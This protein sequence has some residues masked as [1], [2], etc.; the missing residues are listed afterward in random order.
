MSFNSAVALLIPRRLASNRWRWR[1]S[2]CS[3]SWIPECF[4]LPCESRGTRHV[5][6]TCACRPVRR[7][8][9]TACVTLAGYQQ[10]FRACGSGD[11]LRSEGDN[12]PRDNNRFDSRYKTYVGGRRRRWTRGME[13]R[14]ELKI[15][16]AA[17][18]TSDWTHWWYGQSIHALAASLT[19]AV[20]CSHRTA[21]LALIR[22]YR[23]TGPQLWSMGTLMST[24]PPHSFWSIC[25]FV[26]MVLWY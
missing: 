15:T 6:E 20:A 12:R 8:T 16:V 25:A 17:G 2:I 1:K 22:D 14:T 10:S 19:G 5:S 11:V 4:S 9:T 18:R 24:S 13:E 26:D 7:Y 21:P 3:W 23:G